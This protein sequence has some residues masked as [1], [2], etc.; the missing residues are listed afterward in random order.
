[1]E[2]IRT[3]Q[4][5]IKLVEWNDDSF[6]VFTLF[7]MLLGFFIAF[8]EVDFDGDHLFVF[9]ISCS[10]FPDKIS[11]LLDFEKRRVGETYLHVRIRQS[12]IRHDRRAAIKYLHNGVGHSR[13]TAK[14]RTALTY[15]ALVA[16]LLLEFANGGL[17]RGFAFV[18][19]TCR[20]FDTDCVH[21]RSILF[22]QKEFSLSPRSRLHKG[23]TAGRLVWYR[24]AEDSGREADGSMDVLPE[25]SPLSTQ[26]D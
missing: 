6:N 21:W 22:I 14:H 7:E 23:K 4:F 17:F 16:R 13:L 2:G 24:E 19:E 26:V 8:L 9:E 20:K 15:F 18:D 1:M 3:L 25:E 5:L 10:Q 11:F 12:R